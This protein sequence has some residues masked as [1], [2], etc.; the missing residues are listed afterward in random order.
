MRGRYGPTQDYVCLDTS[1]NAVEESDHGEGWLFSLG[2]VQFLMFPQR[3]HITWMGRP[4]G[5]GGG[6]GEITTA[7]AGWGKFYSCSNAELQRD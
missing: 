5:S 2:F 1:R 3:I 6:E 7:A 4:E